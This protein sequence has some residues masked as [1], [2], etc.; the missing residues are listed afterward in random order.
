LKVNCQWYFTLKQINK[1]RVN[2]KLEQYLRIFT[3]YRQEQW[4][5]WLE[6][7]EFT[8][9]NKAYSSIKILLFKTNYGQDSR[10]EF[11]TKR[12]GKYKRVEK[13]V[14]KMKEI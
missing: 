1:Q 12:K 5:D 9:N 8:Y 14:T 13:F 7:A 4:P 3:N 10:M 2:Q 11:E 6:I